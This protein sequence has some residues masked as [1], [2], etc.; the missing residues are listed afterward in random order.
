MICFIV[1]YVSSYT[2]RRLCVESAGFLFF[3]YFLLFFGCRRIGEYISLEQLYFD[4]L[5]S[6]CS[7]I[8]FFFFFVFV[9]L[10]F[11]RPV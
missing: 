2:R 4:S 10:V 8:P 3:I 1:F 6:S 5:T 7:L 11:V 9:F